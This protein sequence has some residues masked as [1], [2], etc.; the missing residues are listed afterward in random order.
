MFI[1][2]FLLQVP[3]SFPHPKSAFL[4]SGT[5]MMSPNRLPR[6]DRGFVVRNRQPFVLLTAM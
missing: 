3:R 4:Y 2:H 6:G 5:W 1:V